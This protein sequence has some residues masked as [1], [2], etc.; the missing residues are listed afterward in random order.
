MK[1]IKLLLV[2]V[3]MISTVPAIGAQSTLPWIEEYTLINYSNGQTVLEWSS[4][5]GEVLQNAAILAGDE[6][7]ITFT[8]N[9]RQ[10][11]D[12]AVLSLSLTSYMTQQSEATY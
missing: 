1:H 2:I 4:E 11:V 6:Y 9:V 3:L 7:Q 8:L 12:N 5:T 10:T